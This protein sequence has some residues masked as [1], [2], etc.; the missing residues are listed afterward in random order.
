MTLRAHPRGL[1]SWALV[2]AAARA[3]GRTILIHPGLAQ[4]LEPGWTGQLARLGLH[5]WVLE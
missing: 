2:R 3:G 5:G 1:R 4:G